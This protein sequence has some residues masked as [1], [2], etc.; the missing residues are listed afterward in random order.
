MARRRLE[1]EASREHLLETATRILMER[2]STRVTVASVAEEAGCAKGLVHYHFKTKARLWE[3]IARHLT[4]A[5]CAAWSDAFSA[6]TPSEAVARSWELLTDESASGF[7]LAW[8]SLTGPQSPLPDQ[9]VREMMDSFREV[10]R[11]SVTTLF[12][13]LSVALRIP[14]PEVAELLTG[15]IAGMGYQLLRTESPEA[16]ENAYAAAWLGIFSLE[17]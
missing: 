9:M 14:I 8:F 17:A 6:N 13:E 1:A 16:C 10:V 4:H 11:T 5:R 15:V 12:D 7:A 3:S 2:G